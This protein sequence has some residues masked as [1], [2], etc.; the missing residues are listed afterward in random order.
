METE[1]FS[2]S[3]NTCGQSCPISTWSRVSWSWQNRIFQQG[4]EACV[5]RGATRIVAVPVILL[6][7][8]HVKLEIPEFLDA[9]RTRYPQPA[10]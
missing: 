5:A 3:R 4:I 8:S 6:A 2:S 9:A 10:D 7:A 1:S